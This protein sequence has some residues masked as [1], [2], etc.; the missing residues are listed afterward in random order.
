MWVIKNYGW[1]WFAVDH[2][3]KR[4]IDCILATRGTVAGARL[5]LSL[6]HQAT[7]AAMADH[8]QVYAEFIPKKKLK[9]Y[10]KSRMWVSIKQTLKIKRRLES[11][12]LKAT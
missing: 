12:G 5:W 7:S 3:K 1:I 2:D 8:G 11:L 6:K 4:F 10:S 9:F